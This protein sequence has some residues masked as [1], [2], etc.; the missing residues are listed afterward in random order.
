MFSFL[1]KKNKTTEPETASEQVETAADITPQSNAEEEPQVAAEAQSNTGLFGRLKSGLSRTSNKLTEGFAS[2][3]LGRKSIDD[4]LLEELET[5]L[6]TADLGVDAT[7]RIIDDLTQRVNRKQL[8]DVEALFNAMREDMVKILEPSAK[9]LVIPSKQGPFVILMVG[10]NGVGKT[11]TI[12]KLAKQFQQQDKKVMLAAGDTFR[13]AAVEQLQ[14]WGERNQIPVIAQPT[15]ADSASVI[16]DALEA[17]KAR[18]VDILIA[19]TAGRLH[20]QSN[21]MEELKKVK[22][23]MA[24]VDATAPH[25]V[26]LVVD[27]GTG[28]NALQQ[29][30]QFNQAVGVTGI[31]LT[32][33]DGTAKGGIIFAIA[34]K[35]GLPIRYIGVGEKID[36]LRPFDANDFVDALLGREDD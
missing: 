17:A 6:L 3:V 34:D 15:G 29:A 26:M 10:I 30:Q 21:L 19:D 25:E 1:R 16:Y 33:L 22:R 14:V 8:G 31:T 13:A 5:Q 18:D 11:T 27:A 32:K 20:T 7:S 23:V 2:L 35:T 36:D 24:K 4:D 28:Q 9:P 12:G